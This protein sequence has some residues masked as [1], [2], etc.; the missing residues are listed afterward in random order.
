V[1]GLPSGQVNDTLTILD[2]SADTRFGST[3]QIPFNSSRRTHTCKRSEE[4]VRYNTDRSRQIRQ[5][6]AAKRLET[7]WQPHQWA[8]KD[9]PTCWN[10][11]DSPVV[12]V[13]TGDCRCVPVDCPPRRDNPL[14]GLKTPSTPKAGY[15]PL[16]V[17]KGYS[18]TLIKATERMDWQDVLLPQARAYLA[19]HP[20]FIKVH[21]ADGYE[22][23]EAIEAA[24]C[25]QLQD[26]HCFSADN[27]MYRAMRHISVPAEDAELVVLPVYQHCTDADFLLHDVMNHAVTTIPGINTGEK[28][29]SLVMTHDWG[30]C[31]AFAW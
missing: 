28:R 14:L 22:G 15:S 19:A 8:I 20:D 24:K 3:G 6:T 17:H 25:H 12:C 11:C 13:Q 5:G 31:I 10:D 9:L 7:A 18:G 1:G 29:V 2:E 21:V 16:G 26:T 30:I 4:A 27:I 23:Q